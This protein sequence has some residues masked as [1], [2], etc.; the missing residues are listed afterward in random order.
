MGAIAVLPDHLRSR[1]SS[2]LRWFSLVP[3]DVSTA[4]GRA[5]ERHRRAA[6]TAVASMLAKLISVGTSLISIPLTLHYLGVER[7]G[8]W[9]TISSLVALLAFA[10][11][12]IA[13]G[14]LNMVA[15]A[16]GRD[17]RA[18]IRRAIASGLFI[19]VGV[20]LALVAA[21]ALAYPWVDWPGVF[22]VQSDIASREAGPA[23]AAFVMCYAATIPLIVVQ[24]AQMGMQQGFLASLWQCAGSMCGLAAVLLAINLQAGLPWLVLA[25]T[26][27]PLL[28]AMLN[29]LYFFGWSRPEFRPNAASVS[30][31]VCRAVAG[32]GALFFVLQLAGAVAYT[33]DNF[34]IAQLLGAPAVA[35]YAVPEKLF[36]VLSL[37]VAVALG[38]LWPAYGEAIARGDAAWVA[39]TVRRSFL[40]A[41]AVGGVG[42]L[43]LIVFGGTIVH[44][45]VR[46]AVAPA[47]GVLVAL[48]CWKLIE[49]GGMSIAMF[50]NGA[51]VIRLQVVCA[52][53]TVGAAIALK[54]FLVPRMG[55]AGAVWASVIAFV[56]FTAV[57]V[58][59]RLPRLMRGLAPRSRT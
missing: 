30:R 45:W 44:L 32:T 26:G 39:K 6:M 53:A 56:L 48:G 49:A 13:N 51:H 15:D 46:D 31:Q 37:A 3:F 2:R 38:P 20:S 58:A 22:N 57:P 7:F 12:G 36:A 9:M 34:V 54:V 33:S 19:L 4:E 21:F 14:V 18:A 52:L 55:V 24:R 1:L 16:H 23:L 47:S 43:F 42:S 35:E 10:D 5:R 41:V 11:F 17:D 25:L 8:M 27:A 50:L 40:T 59:W 28:S 29:T